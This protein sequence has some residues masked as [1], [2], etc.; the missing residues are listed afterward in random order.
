MTLRRARL[1][2]GKLPA[3]G[4][5]TL[6]IERRDGHLFTQYAVDLDLGRPGSLHF[7]LDQ[8]LV[9]AWVGELT[10]LLIDEGPR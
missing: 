1:D 8:D 9:A 10:R 2:L 6:T 4:R 5:H 7:E 3:L